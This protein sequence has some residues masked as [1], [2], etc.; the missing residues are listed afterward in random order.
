MRN[1]LSR[2]LA[3]SILR[4]LIASR[5]IEMEGHHAKVLKTPQSYSKGNICYYFCCSKIWVDTQVTEM[6]LGSVTGWGQSV[7]HAACLMHVAWR[8]VD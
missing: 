6:G 7:L 8:E 1:A 4:V 3:P 5:C 2:G